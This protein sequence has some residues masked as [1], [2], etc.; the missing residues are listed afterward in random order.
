MYCSSKLAV[1]LV[2][3]GFWCVF[4][5]VVRKVLKLQPRESWTEVE[6]ENEIQLSHGWISYFTNH[7]RKNTAPNIYRQLHRL[8]KLTKTKLTGKQMNLP[9]KF[10]YVQKSTLYDMKTASR[11]IDQEPWG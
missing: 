1:A 4:S 8:T 6:T 3:C 10:S 9:I 7:K 5:F 11:L 2:S